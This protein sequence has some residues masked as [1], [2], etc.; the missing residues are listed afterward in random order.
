MACTPQD[1]LKFSAAAK[2]DIGETRVN[3]PEYVQKV[4]QILAEKYPDLRFPP[5]IDEI[6]ERCLRSRKFDC[7]LTATQVHALFKYYL[8]CRLL[9]GDMYFLPS[10]QKEYFFDSLGIAV[11]KNRD[12]KGRVVLLSRM[13]KIRFNSKKVLQS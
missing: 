2:D 6:V 8:D 1:L 9:H 11:L 3:F 7:E 13:G 4:K 5:E 10:I 12:Y